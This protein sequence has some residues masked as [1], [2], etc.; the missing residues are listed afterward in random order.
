MKL[1]GGEEKREG[2]DRVVVV[3]RDK[4]GKCKEELRNGCLRLGVAVVT[5]VHRACETTTSMAC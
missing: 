2:E 1:R 4:K 3:R 5:M